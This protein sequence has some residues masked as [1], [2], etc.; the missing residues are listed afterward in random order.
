MSKKRI[1][2][3]TA[4]AVIVA[5]TVWNYPVTYH[6]GAD[7]RVYEKKISLYAKACGFLYRDWAYK[8]LVREIIGKE[9]DEAKK[10]LAILNWT[11]KNI[12][13]GIP[14][15]LKALDD[16]PLNIIIRQYGAA[17]QVEDIFT[18]LCSYAGM[19]AGWNK[20]YNVTRTKNVILS[21]V[22][23]SGRWLIFDASRNKYFMNIDGKIAS[24]DDC[25]SGNVLMSNE[26]AEVYGE[27]LGNIKDAYKEYS[28]RPDE[29]K[30]LKRIVFELKNIFNKDR[31]RGQCHGE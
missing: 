12:M 25:A 30:P 20:C 11:D 9:E 4:L 14:P 31:N 8:D 21:F 19:E 6:I 18:I 7:G 16:H 3:I 15:G 28:I 26:D 13:R 5:V 23:V 10:A 29:Q 27:F 2:L 22:K 1:L 24:V 17:D